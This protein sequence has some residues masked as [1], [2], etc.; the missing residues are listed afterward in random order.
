MVP[1]IKL[2][3]DSH[4]SMW[5]D[6]ARKWDPKS[7]KGNS[8]LNTTSEIRRGIRTGEEDRM[9]ISTLRT[10]YGNPVYINK[11]SSDEWL[12]ILKGV[13]EGVIWV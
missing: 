9:Q 6:F 3:K 5:M 10:V 1:I 11:H 2:E 13:K 4:G 12:K 7:N 8:W